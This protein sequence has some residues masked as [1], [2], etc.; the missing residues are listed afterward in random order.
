MDLV[1]RTRQT[2]LFDY[3]RLPYSPLK[4]DCKSDQDPTWEEVIT[5]LLKHSHIWEANTLLAIHLRHENTM[6]SD[7]LRILD[8]VPDENDT[9]YDLVRLTMLV[10]C[11]RFLLR[12]SWLVLM[13][14]GVFHRCKECAQKLH[15]SAMDGIT[16][17]IGSSRVYQDF[18]LLRLE[19]LKK[20]P[21][22]NAWDR[23]N[24]EGPDEML[25]IRERTLRNRDYML[26]LASYIQGAYLPAHWLDCTGASREAI[27][28]LHPHTTL[29][30][31]EFHATKS[32]A[33]YFSSA[34]DILN[35]LNRDGPWCEPWND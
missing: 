11:S 35:S 25:R 18:R 24:S 33:G 6:G 27:A 21:P 1:P 5:E 10:S 2:S 19:V 4:L 8:A 7:L 20:G 14:S 30:E 9:M 13:N 31:E 34:D 17:P 15:L 32:D 12:Q 26:L 29:S 23:I 3:K 22:S 16:D 28:C